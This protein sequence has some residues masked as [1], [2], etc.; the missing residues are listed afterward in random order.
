M[1]KVIFIFL[2]IGVGVSVYFR[3]E[4]YTFLRFREQLKT[5]R[6]DFKP[7]ITLIRFG[8]VS[9]TSDDLR[10]FLA[11]LPVTQKLQIAQSPGAITAIIVQLI[12]EISAVHYAKSKGYLDE[13][14]TKIKLLRLIAKLAIPMIESRDVA[15]YVKPSM[16]DVQKFYNENIEMFKRPSTV[17][18]M[19]INLGDYEEAK[20]LRLRIKNVKQFISEAQI[21]HPDLS[22][23]LGYI[24]DGNPANKNKLTNREINILF[25]LKAGQISWPVKTE[26]GWTIFAAVDRLEPGYWNLIDIVERVYKIVQEKKTAERREQLL[27]ELLL[28]SDFFIN[29]E[30]I[31]RSF[32][33]KLQKENFEKL[34]SSSV[35]EK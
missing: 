18:A 6:T 20:K 27:K 5:D 31:E 19:R 32:G 14:S 12:E 28:S 35:K 22:F 3:K 34:L 16:D 17:R 23:D 30:E 2:V 7:G 8:D 9:I 4:I 15:P 24:E 13:P 1:K 33:V 29:F 10:V 26:K 11:E 25:S 21:I